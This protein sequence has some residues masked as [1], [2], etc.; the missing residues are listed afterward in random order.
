[1]RNDVD[2]DEKEFDRDEYGNLTPR[3][4]K[5]IRD[6]ENCRKCGETICPG[7][8]PEYDCYDPL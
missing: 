1:M 4:A 6:C 5:P 2:Y 8:G 3:E 7:V